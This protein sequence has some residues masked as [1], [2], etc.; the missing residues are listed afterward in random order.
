MALIIQGCGKMGF[1]RGSADMRGST[2]LFLF[3]PPIASGVELN[4]GEV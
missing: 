4:M 2:S 1:Q 3:L